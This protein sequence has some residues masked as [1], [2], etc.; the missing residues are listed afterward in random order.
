MDWSDPGSLVQRFVDQELSADERVRLLAR[1]GLDSALRERVIDLE[2]LLVEAG[3]LPKPVVPVAFVS[4]VLERL[5]PPATPWWRRLSDALWTPRTLRFNLAT[6]ALAVL[7]VAATAGLVVQPRLQGTGGEAAAVRTGEAPQA[8]MLVRLVVV[9][10]GARTVAAA[11]DFNGWN[12][13]RTPLAPAANGAWTVT[14]PLHPGRYEYMFVIDGREWIPDPFAVE[15][16]D[17]GFG[18]ENAV[19]DVR[20][21][22]EAPL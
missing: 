19:L 10:P 7:V 9:Q 1:L 2:Q 5:E 22:L 21:P 16:S 14:L 12:P 11:G 18:A 8:P 17:D 3:R 6:A 20:P 13:A 4:R 15:R